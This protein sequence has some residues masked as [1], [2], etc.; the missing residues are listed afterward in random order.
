MQGRAK[1]GMPQARPALRGRGLPFQH[2]A[3]AVACVACRHPPTSRHCQT[4]RT[5]G[6]VGAPIRALRSLLGTV[7]GRPQLQQAAL[8]A[9]R[10][11]WLVV[12]VVALPWCCGT[13]HRSAAQR[14]RGAGLGRAGRVAGG[15]ADGSACRTFFCPGLAA[16]AGGKNIQVTGIVAAMPQP[17]D[18]ALR[19]RLA[20]ES[21][22]LDGVRR[23]A[24]PLID[25]AWYRGCGRRRRTWRPA[26]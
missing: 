23:A 25:L 9:R 6:A 24:A 20:V 11:V 5:A 4:C 16:R 8:A 19:L 21:A 15:R 22:W 10:G 18:V 3:P 7:L 13:G 2:D 14:E 12:C 17:G 1:P 26:K